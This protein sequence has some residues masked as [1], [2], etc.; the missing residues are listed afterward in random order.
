MANKKY[1]GT[2]Q[3]LANELAQ[4][5]IYK[6][7][8]DFFSYN[9]L[10][11]HPEANDVPISYELTFKLRSFIGINSDNTPVFG[12]NHKFEFDLGNNYPLQKPVLKS[13]TDIWHPN[14][15]FFNPGKGRICFNWDVLSNHGMLHLLIMLEDMLKYD[16][17]FALGDTPPYPEDQEVALW[18]REYGEPLGYIEKLIKYHM[19]NDQKNSSEDKPKT[20]EDTIKYFLLDFFSRIGDPALVDEDDLDSDK[21]LNI[22]K[23]FNQALPNTNDKELTSI[24]NF[25]IEGFKEEGKIWVMS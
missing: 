18:V 7:M 24:I 5:E 25:Q 14:I 11:Y 10:K 9:V 2:I 15:K 23:N 6:G 22:F 1:K 13:K 16:N 3:R 19:E 21:L 8:T 4:F 17:Y 12:E 20:I